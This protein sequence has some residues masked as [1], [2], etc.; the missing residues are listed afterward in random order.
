MVK[1]SKTKKRADGEGTIRQLPNGKWRGRLSFGFDSSGKRLQKDVYGDTQGEV[2]SKLAELRIQAA[3]SGKSLVSKDST[4]GFINRW[5]DDHLTVNRSP[6]TVQEYRGVLIRHVLPHI[7][8]V[9]L[10]QLDGERLARWQA[11]LARKGVSNDI[12]FRTVKILRTALNYAVKMRL[13]PFNPAMAIDRPKI[14]KKEMRTLEPEDV[15]RLI[16]VC[17]KERLGDAVILAVTTGLRKGEILGLQWSAVNLSERVL[18]VRYTLEEMPNSRRL[19]EPKTQAGRRMVSLD[20]VAV[21]ALEQRLKKAMEEGFDTDTVPTVFPNE[22]GGFQHGS[23]FDRRVWHPIRK[24]AKLPEDFHFHELR[25]THVSL[26][27][28]A[29]IDLKTIQQRVGHADYSLT[30]NTYSHLLRDAQ[31]EAADRFGVFLANAMKKSSGAKI[32]KKTGEGAL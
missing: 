8:N 16:K 12:R 9:R 23:N 4:E 1:Q 27:L 24:A 29:G 15:A 25:H 28:A 3:T 17:K 20:P 13:L 2:V 31:T 6:K 19:K 14:Q 32:T 5:L 10:N 7:G 18:V 22:L 30:A 11:S 26:S 21:A